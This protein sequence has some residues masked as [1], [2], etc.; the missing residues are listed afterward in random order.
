M[1]FNVRA[2]RG[3]KDC[4][5]AVLEVLQ[6]FLLHGVLSNQFFLENLDPL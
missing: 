6:R 2:M 5:A 3:G 4:G 1:E